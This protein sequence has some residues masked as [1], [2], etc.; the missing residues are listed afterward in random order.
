MKGIRI[1]V[2]LSILSLAVWL[3]IRPTIEGTFEELSVPNTNSSLY[4]LTVYQESTPKS[5]LIP[6]GDPI[7]DQFDSYI[8]NASN[9]YGITDKLM[10]K[11]LIMQESYFDAF[12]ISSDIP[13]GVPDGWTD[14]ESRSFGLTQVTPACGEGHASR[15][16]LTTDKNSPNWATSYF[17]PEFNIDQG[18]KE[19]SSSL[20]L[21]KSKFSGCS[22][23]QYMLM[24]L[25][26]YNSGE[27][28][29]EGCD[30]WNDRADN[31]ITNVTRNYE[32]LSQMVNNIGKIYT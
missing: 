24:A 21:M 20:S 8:I 26:A 32:T 23:E 18:V 7:F 16:N 25:G 9:H 11:S 30:S 10:V 15:P 12:L 5:D 3:A 29:I 27:G 28:A 6:V 2:L 22:D 31:Y 13:C 17:N 14:Q 1:I 4:N 19:L